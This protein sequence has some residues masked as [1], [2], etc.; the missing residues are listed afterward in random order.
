MK[1]IKDFIY[2]FRSCPLCKNWITLDADLPFPT[3]L[4]IREEY[5]ILN[6]IKKDKSKKEYLISFKD[7]SI[8]SDEPFAFNDI[9]S[10]IKRL[11]IQN[12]KEILK[13]EARCYGCSNFRYWSKPM[14]Y[15]EKTKKL[16]NI[17]LAGER[18]RFHE[19]NKNNE[20][21]SYIISNNYNI[22]E[23]EIFIVKSNIKDKALKIKF[24]FTPFKIL[25]IENKDK[26]LDKIKKIAVL[27]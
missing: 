26:I 18:I 25:D 3:T 24:P 15:N 6:V 11:Y 23:T 27:G 17:F 4:E 19:L 7:N 13:I 1:S 20:N 9:V 5:L 10:I 16:K 22:K 12:Y 2:Y 21:I 14:F 8:I